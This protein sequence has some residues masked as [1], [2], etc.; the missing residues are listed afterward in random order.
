MVSLETAKKLILDSSII[1]KHLRKKKEETLLIQELET[2]AKLA[3]T[4]IN[5]F[6][7][8]YGA[9]RFG[10][11]RRNL[12]AAKGFLST[13]E[14]LVMDEVSAEIA[15]QT[16]AELRSKGQA[17]DIRDL[18]VGC[19]AIRNGFT[20]LTHNKQHFQRIPKLHVITPTELK[21]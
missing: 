19:I 5:A 21:S 2:R 7:T 8:Y 15:G 13:L 3:T 20:V 16:I 14:L 9:Y 11:V 18:F 17:I 10:D 12:A 1:I 6:E 4:V